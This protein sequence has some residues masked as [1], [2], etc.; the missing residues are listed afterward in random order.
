MSSS[1]RKSGAKQEF[2]GFP[3]VSF[4]IRGVFSM[5]DTDVS[6]E[7]TMAIDI[8]GLNDTFVSQ[9]RGSVRDGIAALEDVPML[10]KAVLKK[11][12]W[13]ERRIKPGSIVRFQRFE[14]FVEAKPLEGLGCTVA[15]L[16]RICRDDSEAIDLIDRA[17]GSHQMSE[18]ECDK[19]RIYGLKMALR[20]ALIML[21]IEQKPYPKYCVP[22]YVC[23]DLFKWVQTKDEKE[24]RKTMQDAIDRMASGRNPG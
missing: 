9:L 8:L 1:V 6:N 11:G 22:Y 23:G 15:I 18:F 13:K 2:F 7:H 21:C 20:E 14:E 4:P 16:R 10:L 5:S 17:I 19:N 24:A 3:P 12:C